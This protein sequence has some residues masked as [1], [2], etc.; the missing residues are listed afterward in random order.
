MHLMLPTVGV[1]LAIVAWWGAS[2]RI[3]DLSRLR[4]EQ[5]SAHSKAEASALPTDLVEAKAGITRTMAQLDLTIA[6]LEALVATKGDLDKPSKDSL[7]AIESLDNETKAL[8]TRGDEMRDRGAA[9]FE[10]WE[11]QLAAM[12]TPEVVAIASKR[13]DELSAK[14]AEV[15]TAMQESRAALDAFWDDM[16]PIR[17]A[18]DDGL[19]PDK[20]KLL[21]PQVKSAKEKAAT[22]K[23]RVEATFAKLN[24]VGLM[25][26][27]H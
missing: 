10:A 27:K 20:H 13:K 9:Y 17:S 23:T 26:T 3:P 14:Y 8:K 16:K 11:K 19:T 6:K 25:Y 24:E 7:A 15:L 2:L 12:S 22:L 1:G 5:A 21:G 18:L 4:A